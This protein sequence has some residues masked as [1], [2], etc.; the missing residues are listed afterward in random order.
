MRVAGI[1]LQEIFHYILR[2]EISFTRYLISP[3][4]QTR[5]CHNSTAGAGLEK[6]YMLWKEKEK[7][8]Q[9]VQIVVN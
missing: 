3:Y 7:T 8:R 1:R 9:I 6:P 4:A 2:S 5:S